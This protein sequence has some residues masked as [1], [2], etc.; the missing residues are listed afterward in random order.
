M[1]HDRGRVSLDRP[2]KLPSMRTDVPPEAQPSLSKL[3]PQESEAELSAGNLQVFSATAA[4]FMDI[5]K[6]L[7]TLA[8]ANPNIAEDVAGLRNA[9]RQVARKALS[10]QGSAQAPQQQPFLGAQ[11]GLAVRG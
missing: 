7:I 6:A 9:V 11:A 2:P 1:A 4:G 3:A 5:E 8:E 10:S